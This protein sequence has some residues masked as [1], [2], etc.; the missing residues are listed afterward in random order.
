MKIV[1]FSMTPLFPDVIMGGSQRV[2]KDVALHLGELGHAVRVVCTKRW[3]TKDVFQWG[4]NVTVH[5]IFDFKQPYPDPYATQPY[6]IANSIKLLSDYL[7]DADRLYIHD[8]A[9]LF[10]YVYKAYP[11]MTV[12]ASLRDFVYSESLLGAFLFQGDSLILPSEYAL[13]VYCNTVGRF[14]PGLSKRTCVIPNGIRWETSSNANTSTIYNHLQIQNDSKRKIILYPHR[15]ELSKGIDHVIS[16]VQELVLTYKQK[17]ILVLVPK[18]LETDSNPVLKKQY[19]LLE[20]KLVDLKLRQYFHFHEWVPYSLMSQYYRLGDC[21]LCLGGYPETFGNVAY[22]S[23]GYGTPVIATRI[24]PNR[25]SLG[26]YVHLVE[27]GDNETA[28][29]LCVDI[30]QQGKRVPNKTISQLQSSYSLQVMCQEYAKVILTTPKKHAL[31]YCPENNQQFRFGKIAPW[32]IRH[33]GMYYN[34]LSGLYLEHS[35]DSEFSLTWEKYQYRKFPLSQKSNKRFL[36]GLDQGYYVPA[37][38]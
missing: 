29:T 33:R 32:I 15:P 5:P 21:T 28:A 9:F 30:L 25:Y 37:K 24:G 16:V 14:F 4:K 13:D 36:R 18:W 12:I 6:H 8:S 27:L 3:D 2:L 22:E 23:I 7:Y 20:K 38:N 35:D 34:E 17:S 26:Q 19:E 1:I 11:N 31:R 10:S